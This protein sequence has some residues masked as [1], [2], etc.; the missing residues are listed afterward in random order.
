MIRIEVSRSLSVTVTRHQNAGPGGLCGPMISSLTWA[1]T[2]PG[3]NFSNSIA[4][5]CKGRPLPRLN[6][7]RC[8]T[9]NAFVTAGSPLRIKRRGRPCQRRLNG[10][11]IGSPN[12]PPRWRLPPRPIRSFEEIIPLIPPCHQA[13]SGWTFHRIRQHSGEPLA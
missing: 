6:R 7:C 5:I 3:A 8:P 2:A 1:I 12:E 10:V 4:D 9:S 11:C 13:G